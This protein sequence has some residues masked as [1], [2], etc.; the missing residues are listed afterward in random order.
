SGAWATSSSPNPERSAGPRRAGG[1]AGADLTAI[2]ATVPP[3]FTRSAW[4]DGPG[5]GRPRAATVII[6]RIDGGIVGT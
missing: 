1:S 6:E 3:D 2:G 4:P 5:A